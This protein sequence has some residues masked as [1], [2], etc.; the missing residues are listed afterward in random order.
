MESDDNLQLSMFIKMQS[1][2]LPVAID[3]TDPMNKQAAERGRKT[4]YRRIGQR[5]HACADC[6]AQERVEEKWLGGRYIARA[7]A[8]L[9]LTSYNFV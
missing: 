1:N 2:G 6:H 4:F 7:S 3:L 8:G 5:N 9:A